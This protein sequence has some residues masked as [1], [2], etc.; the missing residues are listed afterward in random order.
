MTNKNAWLAIIGI[1]IVVL[2]AYYFL[3]APSNDVD[4]NLAN[5]FKE[6][7]VALAV[8]DVGQPIEGFDADLLI[9][10][11]AGLEKSDFN[12]VEALE[13]VYEI[14]ED[15]SL[16]FARTQDLPASSAERTIADEG[17]ATLLKNIS[18]RLNISPEDE[19]GIDALIENLNLSERVELK[20]NEEKTVLGVSLTPLEVLEDSR[21]PV[22]VTCIQAGT[23][24]LRALLKSG[25]GEA[26]QIFTMGE[27]VTTEAE[28]FSLVFVEPLARSTEQINPEDYVFRFQIEK[29]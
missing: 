4:E 28:E 16:A 7:L 20:L 29:R 18:Q 9:M 10:A 15:G 5:Y 14:K 24:R 12:G 21:C 2:G 17:Y 3:P 27:V 8:E 1:A 13:G 6:E 25:L 19:S 23:V 26:G 22:D 11:Y